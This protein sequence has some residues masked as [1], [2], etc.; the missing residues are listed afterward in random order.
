MSASNATDFSHGK[1]S[2]AEDVTSNLDTLTRSRELAERLGQLEQNNP[3]AATGEYELVDIRLQ[4]Q[5]QQMLGELL[6]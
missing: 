6:F 1:F 3:E 2:R 5:N 4:H